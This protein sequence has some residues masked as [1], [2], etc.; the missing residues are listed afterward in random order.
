MQETNL[1]A[2]RSQCLTASALVALLL[3]VI[4]LQNHMV[5]Q[6]TEPDVPVGNEPLA[7]QHSKSR[8]HRIR[9]AQL[10]GP[11]PLAKAICSNYAV[12]CKQARETLKV[13]MEEAV[14][15]SVEPSLA[16]GLALHESGF[17]SRKVSETGDHGLLQVNYKWH[18]TEV[19]R[20]RDLYDTRT[21][22]RIGLSYL[23]AL[24]VRKG[25]VR[26]ALRHY[27]GANGTK[28]YP[29]EVLKKAQWVAQYI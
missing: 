20:L 19:R 23:K 29:E 15:H 28:P 26:V 11:E 13:V 25:D 17:D 4:A 24:L 21:N 7:L 27:N 9:P 2:L 12:S 18:R 5:A 10:K 3:G 14:Y 6:D 1:A 16:V 8:P 22:T